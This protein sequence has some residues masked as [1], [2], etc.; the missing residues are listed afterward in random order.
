[1]KLIATIPAVAFAGHFH[2][3]TVQDAAYGRVEQVA[4]R[5]NWIT[6]RRLVPELVSHDELEGEEVEEEFAGNYRMERPHVNF[7]LDF[8]NRRLLSFRQHT[9]K[10]QSARNMLSTSDRSWSNKKYGGDQ[11]DF[12]NRDNI[13]NFYKQSHYERQTRPTRNSLLRRIASLENMIQYQQNGRDIQHHDK[14]PFG[15]YFDYG[16]HCF[17]GSF[18]D[19]K[20]SPHAQPVDEIDR[21]CRE[22]SWAYDCAKQDFGTDCRGKYQAYS[23]EG[24]I[25]S[26]GFTPEIYC[27]D[28]EEENPCAWA[29]CQADKHLAE[30]LRD[31]IKDYNPGN[32]VGLDSNFKQFDRQSICEVTQIHDG[33]RKEHHNN[34]ELVYLNDGQQD[35][36][37]TPASESPASN[38]NGSSIPIN[39]NPMSGDFVYDDN[40]QQEDEGLPEDTPSPSS[41]NG[42]RQYSSEEP[43]VSFISVGNNNNPEPEPF[44]F[45]EEY[46]EMDDL[47]SDESKVP[48]FWGSPDHQRGLWADTYGWPIEEVQKKQKKPSNYNFPDYGMPTFGDG[49][50]PPQDDPFGDFVNNQELQFADDS[51]PATAA[52]ENDHQTP[53]VPE[54]EIDE[55]LNVVVQTSVGNTAGGSPPMVGDDASDFGG[56]DVLVPSEVGYN[57]E[58]KSGGSPAGSEENSEEPGEDLQVTLKSAVTYSVKQCCGQYPTRYKYSANKMG[59]C[60]DNGIEKLYSP[61]YSKC[62]VV[63]TQRGVMGATYA[64]FLARRSDDCS[65]I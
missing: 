24:R 3:Q 62:C 31:L 30:R 44:Q 55:H 50:F 64:S 60:K 39:N 8:S 45:E 11:E 21:A 42:G 19:P 52:P 40:S 6:E 46:L 20:H 27:V 41:L 1:M 59:C 15:A 33:N 25:G 16:C 61:H 63:K 17:P 4:S 56:E 2:D 12:E 9:N 29:I 22:H 28:K 51:I 43:E 65:G 23:W 13:Y 49:N 35:N 48:N 54:D 14:K 36:N 38:D 32:Q 7:W 47:L 37:Q 58:I 5:I 53:A 57:Q 18:M 10:Y 26:D 34:D